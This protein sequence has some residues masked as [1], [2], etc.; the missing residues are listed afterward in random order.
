MK[1]LKQLIK[2]KARFLFGVEK[3]VM[4]VEVVSEVDLF[5][6]EVI[7][8]IT[9]YYNEPTCIYIEISKKS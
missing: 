6:S 2:E 8:I 7:N 1:K 5:Y 4:N 3:E 9:D